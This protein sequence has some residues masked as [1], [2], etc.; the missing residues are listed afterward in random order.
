MIKYVV[1][2]TDFGET[3]D[4]LA[5]VSGVFDTLKAAQEDMEADVQTYLPHC[6]LEV[7]EE[8]DKHVLVGTEYNG[9]QWQILELEVSNDKMD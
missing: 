6:L 8:S 3:C 2:Y 7:T 5:R 9:C 4:G 1:I